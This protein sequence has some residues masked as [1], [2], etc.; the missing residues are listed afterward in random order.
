MIA[1]IFDTF[2]VPSFYVGIQ[3]V[4]SLSTSGR[5]TGLV[6]EIGDGLIQF[7]PIVKGNLLPKG[8]N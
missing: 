5:D 6:L 1:V 8:L 2:N 4:L 3:A 7:A